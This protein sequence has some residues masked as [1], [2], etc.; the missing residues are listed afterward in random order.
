MGIPISLVQL[1]VTQGGCVGRSQ[2]IDH[3]VS[4]RTI[5]RMIAAGSI[6][7]AVA[8][9]YRIIESRGWADDVRAAVFALPGA[10]ASHHAAAAVLGFPRLRPIATVLVHSRT[11]HEF[12]GV[13]VHRVHDVMPEHVTVIDGLR[14]TT[15]ARTVVDL[16]AVIHPKHLAAII[17]DLVLTGDVRTSEIALALEDVARRG[18][19]GVRSLRTTLEELGS[20]PLPMTVLERRGWE[21]LS[22]RGVS[23]GSRQH[24]IP[25]DE[26]KRF[27]VAWPDHGVAIEW[28]SR[29]WHGAL[30][31]MANDRERDRAAAINGW[32]VLRFTWDDVTRR[33]DRVAAD[34]RAMLGSPERRRP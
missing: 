13:V 10:L 3:G 17:Q 22:R 11:T 27:D 24:P 18:K 4:A 15:A 5:D 31:R 30:D 7:N 14:T 34:V 8:D 23:G 32:V 1:A 16:A 26:S 6:G 19:P 12:P 28:D 2:L 20:D 25:W 33:P 9:V 29:R 21:L